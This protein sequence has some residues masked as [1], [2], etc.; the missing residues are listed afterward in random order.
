M[1][2]LAGQLDSKTFSLEIGSGN[3]EPILI[4]NTGQTL[5]AIPTVRS[6]DLALDQGRKLEALRIARQQLTENE[7]GKS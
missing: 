4:V 2:K 3:A 5:S 7:K 1:L 6:I